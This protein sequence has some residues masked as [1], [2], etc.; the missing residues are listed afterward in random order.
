MRELVIV[1][2]DEL[3]KHAEVMRKNRGMEHEEPYMAHVKPGS[4]ESIT[5]R[6]TKPGTFQ[7]CCLVA[8]HYECRHERHDR[9]RGQQVTSGGKR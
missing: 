5:W 9:G 8:G 2:E 4:K 3:K 1:T 6:F 7:F